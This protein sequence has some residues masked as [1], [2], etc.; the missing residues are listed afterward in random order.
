MSGTL[1]EAFCH[2]VEQFE[3]AELFSFINR[4]AITMNELREKSERTAGKLYSL[5]IRK[6]SRIILQGSNS[7][8]WLIVFFA[9]VSMGAVPILFPA[10][11]NTKEY[12]NFLAENQKIDLILICEYKFNFNFAYF[13]KICGNIKYFVFAD[14]QRNDIST[15][16]KRTMT[17]DSFGR[18][19]LKNEEKKSCDCKI[20]E[21]DTAFVLFSSGSGG[22]P[23]CIGVSNKNILL[24]CRA[25]ADKCGITANDVILSAMPF[26]HIMGLRILLETIICGASVVIAD[27][28]DAKLHGKYI[29]RSGATLTVGV[30]TMYNAVTEAGSSADMSGL[31]AVIIGGAPA[32]KAV[33]GKIFD[34][35]KVECVYID[36]GMTEILF[37]TL[38]CLTKADLTDYHSQVGMP[39]E[40]LR[41]KAP[42]LQDGAGKVFFNGATVTDKYYSGVSARGDDGWLCTG[43]VGAFDSKGCL[44]IFGREKDV[45][46]K[47]GES[48]NPAE[49]EQITMEFAGVTDAYVVGIRDKFYG[50]KAVACISFAGRFKNSDKQALLKFITDR[51]SYR[52]VPC[53]VFAFE[54]FPQ[55]ASGKVNKKS[56]RRIAEKLYNKKKSRDEQTN[57]F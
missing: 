18:D 47:G 31:R 28:F 35:I 20:T 51:L 3:N 17:F 24:S 23:K 54:K 11:F 36:Y 48:I 44:C 34:R 37:G 4:T 26:C 5:G 42:K 6:G 53:E 32:S 50:Q 33:L 45:I 7:E 13:D 55:T 41:V 46:N 10:H 29:E 12:I 25:F 57:G 49:I 21:N 8:E 2:A 38:C 15:P 22:K 19:F 56:L 40:Y 14:R 52:K 9:C 1:K 27:K 43:D 30:P 39:P 16:L